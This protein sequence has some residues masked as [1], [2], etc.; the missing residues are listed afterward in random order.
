LFPDARQDLLT[1][2][3][4]EHDAPLGNKL[5]EFANYVFKFG[6]KNRS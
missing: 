5:F 3:S 1:D 2:R 4:E 6:F